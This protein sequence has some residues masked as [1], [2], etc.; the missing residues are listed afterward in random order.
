[1]AAKTVSWLIDQLNTC[2][3]R[4]GGL[5]LFIIYAK[6]ILGWIFWFGNIVE[7][8]VW[9]MTKLI[10]EFKGWQVCKYGQQLL[11]M[12]TFVRRYC[13]IHAFPIWIDS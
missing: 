9:F 3:A 10:G 4:D 12:L 1:M 7:G 13:L 8:F 6:V 11:K 5:M 2:A